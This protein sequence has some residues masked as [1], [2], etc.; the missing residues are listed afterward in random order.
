M[1]STSDECKQFVGRYLQALSG[2]RKTPELVD[3]FVA[4]PHLRTHIQEVEGAF[5]E[6]ELIA[7]DLIAEGDR[8]AFEDASCA[9][10]QAKHGLATIKR[11]KPKEGFLRDLRPLPQFR[12]ERRRPGLHLLGNRR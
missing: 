10:Q 12:S 11:R 3:R 7:E 2:Q 9:R 4:D 6:Y 1:T 5:P 8:V